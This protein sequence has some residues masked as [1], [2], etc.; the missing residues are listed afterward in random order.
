MCCSNWLSISL[1]VI[2][3][4]GLK[5]SGPCPEFHRRWVGHELEGILVVCFIRYRGLKTS[6]PRPAISTRGLG[7][8]HEIILVVCFIGASG[9]P[10]CGPH[11]RGGPRT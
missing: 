2:R 10:P 11:T 8:E 3:Y 5:T 7:R 4:R 9:P 1:Y 6:G